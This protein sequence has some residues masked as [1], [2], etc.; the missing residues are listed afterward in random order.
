MRFLILIL[1]VFLLNSCQNN[2]KKILLKLKHSKG[3]IY[4]IRFQRYK[5][6]IEEN[7]IVSDEVIA[8]RYK[9]DS[10]L[11]DTSYVLTCNIEGTK[12]HKPHTNPI[13]NQYYSSE[14]EESSMTPERKEVHKIFNSIKNLKLELIIS[15]NGEIIRPYKFPNNLTTPIYPIDYKLCQIL[16]PKDPIAIGEEWKNEDHIPQI[17]G[18]RTTYFKIEHIKESIIKINAKGVANGLGQKTDFWGEYYIDEKS[19]KLISAKLFFDSSSSLD[20]KG[21]ITV[22]IKV[23]DV[24]S[25]PTE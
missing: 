14:E 24:I 9:V 11:G 8:M 3:D 20:G 15:N 2:D 25:F 4:D 16:F 23:N 17:N 22:D 21:L 19:N 1:L 13:L 5:S 18:K 6:F 7:K 12:Y 10:I